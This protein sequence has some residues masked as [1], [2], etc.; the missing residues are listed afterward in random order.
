VERHGAH[1][2][3]NVRVMRPRSLLVLAIPLALACDSKDA[4]PA[5][6]S[7]T[8]EADSLGAMTEYMRKSKT[9][10]A[11]VN[12]R[13]IARS[14]I[15]ASEELAIGADGTPQS[16]KLAH[17]PLTPAA[18]ECCKHPKG[19]CPAGT[20]DWKQPG[21][22]ALSFELADPHYYSYELVVDP[23]GFIVRA[24]GDLDCDGDLATFELRGTTKPD[25]T[26][27]L[28]PQPTSDKPLE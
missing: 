28:A 8:P 4:A 22:Q 27:E 7:G 12:L 23:T 6:A 21:W 14:V 19:K 18:G 11:Q 15:Y 9:A 24:V 10:E 17:A 20:G 1:D 26:Y 5:A 13:S 25:G 3:D 2:G 16:V